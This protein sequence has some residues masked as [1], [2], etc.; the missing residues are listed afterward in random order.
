MAYTQADLDNVQ[1]AIA[2]GEMTVRHNGRE[3]TYRSIADLRKAE[4]RIREDL[5]SQRACR[6]SG[7]SWSYSFTTQ[8]GD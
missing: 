1:A 5:A 7:G 6:P 3:V 2:S 8:R 4:D